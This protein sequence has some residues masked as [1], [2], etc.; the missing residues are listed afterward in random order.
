MSREEAY[1]IP[2]CDDELCDL[3][4][5]ETTCPS[6]GKYI[7]DY[8]VWWDADDVYHGTERVFDC[9]HCKSSLVVRWD[10]EQIEYY[11]ETNI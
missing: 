2:H 1:F 9:E 5:F 6:C 3:G 11:V 7:V 8:D 4:T 10:K